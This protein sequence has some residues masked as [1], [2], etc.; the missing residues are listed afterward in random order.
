MEETIE[1]KLAR[2]WS[3][4]NMYKHKG[5]IRNTTY[6]G[7]CTRNKCVFRVY[8][9][10]KGSTW[11]KTCYVDPITEEILS[12]EKKIFGKKLKTCRKYA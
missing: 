7:I 12:D 5:E 1:Q 2:A 4:E 3:Y 8:E 11:Y 9:D 6:V 10:D